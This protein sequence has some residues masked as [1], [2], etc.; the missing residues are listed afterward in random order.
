MERRESRTLEYKEKVTNT[1]LKTVSAYANF[2]GGCVI[3]G[4]RD[5]GATVGVVNPSRESLDIE[6][7]INDNLHPVPPY[8]IEVDR[9]NGVERIILT[10]Q[11]GLDKPY[12]YKGKAYKR[13]DTATIEVDRLELGRL[14]LEGMNRNFE[15]LPSLQKALTFRTLG[16]K[17]REALKIARL[18]QDILK[19]LGL[20]SDEEGYNRAAELL[21]D[22]NA[23]PGIDMVRFGRDIDELTDR[24]TWSNMSV[25]SL[26]DNALEMFRK[27]YQYERIEGASRVPI[28]RIPEKA[29]REA[30]ANG[31]VHRAW[32]VNAAIQISLFQDRVEVV[33]PGGLPPGL[34]EDEYLSNQISVLRNPKLANALFRLSYIEKFGTGIR[35][36]R[37]AYAGQVIKPAFHVYTES[38]RVVLPVIDA[39][40][41]LDAEERGVLALL[42]VGR[43][44][45]RSEIEEMTGYGKAKVLRLLLRLLDKNALEKAGTG[46]GTKYRR[47]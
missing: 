44:L 43:I 40:D 47:P 37:N 7:R 8:T 46:R 26:R 6:N 30:L 31:I 20:Y 41:G 9:A 42:P 21:A 28:E 29:F 13:N 34:S 27:Y 3:F 17:M 11:G 12:L 36:I 33:S 38:V 14:A 32:D 19:T 45:T 18:N 25:L 5:D 4:V 39:G 15:D 22:V 10:V 24:G 2:G 35:R 1:F 16:A 23:F